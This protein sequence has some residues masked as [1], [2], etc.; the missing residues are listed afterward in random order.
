[1]Y[2]SP[3]SNVRLLTGV[4]LDRTYDHTIFFSSATTQANYF[5]SRTKHNL[6]NYTYQRVNKGVCRAGV[7]ADSC[8][9]CNYMMFQNSAY[10]TKWFYAFINKIEFVN[11]E[12]CDIYFEID[13]LQ[14][15]LFV[16]D[17]D[18][19]FVER[20]HSVLDIFGEHIE[21]EPVSI[22]EYV[23]N[24]Y[25]PMYLMTGTAVMIAVS[26]NAEAADGNLY[27][28]IFGGAQLFVYY[29]SDVAGINSKINEYAQKPDAIIG[30]Y[31]VPQIF[32]KNIPDDHRVPNRSR[33]K[34][35]YESLPALS[36]DWDLDGY[37][38]KNNKMYT[39]PFNFISVDNA[40]GG[41]LTARY[42]FFEGRTPQFMMEGTI[43]QPVTAVLR[44]VAYKGSQKGN[45]ETYPTYNCESIELK[46]YPLC[47]WN[48]DAY[49]AYVAQNSVPSIISGGL[50]GL[51]GIIQAAAGNVPGGIGT[52]VGQ[53]A[54]IF[55]D[56]YRAS[57]A[58]DITKGNIGNSSVNLASM[59]QQFYWG[60]MSLTANEARRIDEFLTMFGY[61]CGRVKKPNRSS[62]PHWNYVKTAGCVCTGSI[63]SD[64]L[65]K[66]C[67][68]HNS[69]ITY[70][71]NASEIGNYG[72]NN[73]PTQTA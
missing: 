54:S 40:S 69:G 71:K 17:I 4:P 68:I 73:S 36:T 72:L 61:T 11:N 6:T 45:I 63:P 28:G 26:D 13:V 22:S 51:S 67:E 43:T 21:P 31:I 41:S 60:R 7:S 2:I 49:Q 23:L 30:M 34:Q 70:W 9:D 33:A 58:A 16:F 5:I 66:I 55:N 38:P 32:F 24:N 15:W 47:S 57:N 1:M 3:Q 8:Y 62:R 52:V 25:Q 42:E 18:Y 59:K 19:C 46:N 44:P 29:S 27:D 53:A 48:V 35:N 65:A 10:G 39:Y 20:E 56:Y 50:G 37:V 14:T 64:D 12:T